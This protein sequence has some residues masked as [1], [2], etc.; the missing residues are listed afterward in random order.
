VP[1]ENDE[2]IASILKNSKTIAV[3]GASPKPWRDSGNITQY[4]M[5]KGYDVY[6]VNPAHQELFGRRCYKDLSSIPVPVDIVDVFRNPD[7]VDAVVE[8]AIAVKAKTVWLQL[9]VVNEKAAA[10]AE[11]AGLQVIMDHCIAVDH[12][13]LIK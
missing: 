7:A 3:V 9:G 6:P 4:L 1:I 5:R 8:E 12:S 13:R 10:K 2:T 11:T